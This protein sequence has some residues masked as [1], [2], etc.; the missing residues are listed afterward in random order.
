MAVEL[1]RGC[2]ETLRLQYVIAEMGEILK[3]AYAEYGYS[4]PSDSESDFESSL[5]WVSIKVRSRSY[6]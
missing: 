4:F 2:G 5:P 3:E 1:A 6:N